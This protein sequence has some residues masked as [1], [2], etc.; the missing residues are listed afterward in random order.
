MNTLSFSGAMYAT[1]IARNEVREEIIRR[2]IAKA[3]ND[4]PHTEAEYYRSLTSLRKT[5]PCAESL[6]LMRWNKKDD[7]DYQ[8]ILLKASRTYNFANFRGFFDQQLVGDH[9][10]NGVQHSTIRLAQAM[11]AQLVA[12]LEHKNL[13]TERSLL[14]D[15]LG[16]INRDA[17]KSWNE[18]ERAASAEGFNQIQKYEVYVEGLFNIVL[19]AVKEKIKKIAILRF[20]SNLNEVRPNDSTKDLF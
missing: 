14:A 9:T 10:I 12:E 8:Q 6:M 4:L 7:K 20:F 3:R 5:N 2:F 17:N 16:A 15:Q 19:P 1:A 18:A 11:K 13:V